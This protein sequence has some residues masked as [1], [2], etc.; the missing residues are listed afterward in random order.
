M[1]SID[2]AKE[3]LQ[4]LTSFEEKKANN[5]LVQTSYLTIYKSLIKYC[6]EHNDED[7]DLY[8]QQSFEDKFVDCELV[9]CV[10]K[11]FKEKKTKNVMESNELIVKARQLVN[12]F[13]GDNCPDTEMMCCLLDLIGEEDEESVGFVVDLMIRYGFASNR[14]KDD[15]LVRS[16]ARFLENPNSKKKMEEMIE[17]NKSKNDFNAN[18]LKK[19]ITHII[20]KN[21]VLTKNKN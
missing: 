14:S 6:C 9:N 1:G 15:P 5:K 13:V 12:L 8:I 3:L 16:L 19:L 20:N 7:L 21:F 17:R 18:E 10:L 4:S 11:F 2:R